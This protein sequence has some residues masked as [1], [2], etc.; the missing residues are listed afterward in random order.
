MFNI[1]KSNF[2]HQNKE[3]LI[4]KYQSLSTGKYPPDAMWFSMAMCAK[5]TAVSLLLFFWF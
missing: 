4:N 1:I 5:D 3:K 2:I